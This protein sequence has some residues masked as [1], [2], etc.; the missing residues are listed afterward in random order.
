MILSFFLNSLRIALVLFVCVFSKLDFAFS[1]TPEVEKF[2]LN[3]YQKNKEYDK[4]VT[5]LANQVDLLRNQLLEREK[6]YR[7]LEQ[8]LKED[9]SVK[10]KLFLQHTKK[11]S[12]EIHQDIALRAYR[13]ARRLLISERYQDALK[14]F[15]AYIKD[16]PNSQHVFDAKYWL[17]RTYMANDKYDKTLEILSSLQKEKP[18]YDKL[19]SVLFDLADLYLAQSEKN[20]YSVKNK[21]VTKKNL[22]TKTEALVHIK[23]KLNAKNKAIAILKSITK[24]FPN[25]KVSA[26]AK[27]KLLDLKAN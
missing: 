20:I 24:H 1:M 26:Q 18:S 6:H 21:K 2:I 25:H 22:Q 19:P 14:A 23:E 8:L 4:K 13:G 12:Q 10:N 7:Q 15:N 9:R 5:E 11:T 27:K 17:A 3:Q 16:Y